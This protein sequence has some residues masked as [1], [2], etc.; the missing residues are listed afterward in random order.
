M[1]EEWANKPPVIL[2]DGKL[3]Y[4]AYLNTG[5]MLILREALD[6]DHP[7]QLY[8]HLKSHGIKPEDYGVRYPLDEIAEQEY[9]GVSREALISELVKAKRE[10]EAYYRA[11]Y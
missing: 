7:E 10:L 11:G 3:Q 6:H 1:N 2:E 5:T 8:N 9:S 4:Q